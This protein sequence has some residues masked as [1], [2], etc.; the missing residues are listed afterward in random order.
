[1]YL[2]TSIQPFRVYILTITVFAYENLHHMYT[3]PPHAYIS[4]ATKVLLLG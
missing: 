4:R 3:S 2:M 1:M